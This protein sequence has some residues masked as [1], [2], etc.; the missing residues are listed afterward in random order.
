MGGFTPSIPTATAFAVT[1]PPWLTALMK[2]AAPGFSSAL[3]ELVG[4]D[5]RGRRHEDDCLPPL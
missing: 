1:M 3:A 5:R 2:T 4:H